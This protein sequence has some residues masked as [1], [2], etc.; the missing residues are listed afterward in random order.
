VYCAVDNAVDN[1]VDRS[2]PDI[3]RAPSVS[4]PHLFSGFSLAGAYSLDGRLF[5][6]KHTRLSRLGRKY[7]DIRLLELIFGLEGPQ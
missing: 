2:R 5:H 3:L 7:R 6:V 1:F 4:T